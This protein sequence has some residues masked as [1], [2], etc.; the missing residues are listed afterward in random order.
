MLQ[1]HLNTLRETFQ[2]RYCIP[3]LHFRSV[4]R[5]LSRKRVPSE[6]RRYGRPILAALPFSRM[7]PGT[8]GDPAARELASTPDDYA[9][10]SLAA[11]LDLPFRLTVISMS[12]P[13]IS[14]SRIKRSIE[15][16]DS[17]PCLSAEILG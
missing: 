14:K 3:L 15:K 5:A 6:E 4:H 1:Q 9:T 7:A 2:V 8:R 16:P 17:L 10:R 12:R 11:G 13:S